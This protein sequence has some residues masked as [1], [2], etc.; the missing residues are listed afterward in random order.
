MRLWA[1]VVLLGAVLLDC[2]NGWSADT[3]A[4]EVPVAGKSA[5]VIPLRDQIDKPLF[6][7][8]R[9]GV[10]EAMEAKADV[11]ILDMK[12]PGGELGVTLEIIDVLE[13]FPGLTVTYINNEA[14]SAGA[15]V[16]YGTREIYMSERSIIGASAPIMGGPMGLTGGGEIPDTLKQ[17]V[18]SMI[19]AQMRACAERYSHNPDVIE[20]MIDPNQELIIEGNTLSPQGELLTL[21]NE[22]AARQYGNPPRPLLSRGTV[23]SIEELFTVLGVDP[24]KVT[25]VEKIGVESLASW[26][27]S[28]SSLLLII[29]GLGLFIEYKTPG[30]GVF[31]IVGISALVI[32]FVGNHIAGLGGLEWLLF[33]FLGV[34]LIVVEVFFL[35]GSLFFGAS[36][37][38]I[39]LISLIMAMVDMYPGGNLF[40]RMSQLRL[41]FFNL[42]IAGVSLVAL[43]F[44]LSKYFPK[45]S[46]YTQMISPGASGEL[47][48]QEV[49]ALQKDLLGKEGVSL[50]V[51]RPGGKALL[52]GVSLDVIAQNGMIPKGARI[53]VIA[54]SGRDPIVEEINEG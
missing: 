37:M 50:S 11:L 42:G 49:E 40:P 1:L 3:L 15:F 27:S 2:V 23:P 48:S 14:I 52:D 21:T 51:L 16:S 9:R 18:V 36:G 35:P 34:G 13:Q 22:E 53:K 33:F 20:A 6:Y 41:S 7:V 4:Q 5:Y 38:L 47:E 54:M 8:I 10:K 31:G 46:L 30:F 32:Y 28:W 45:T 26:I 43:I 25:Y 19:R 44:L 39:V 17:K 24:L 29:G 12:T